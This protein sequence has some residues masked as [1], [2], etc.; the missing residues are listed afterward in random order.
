MRTVRRKW[1]WTLLRACAICYITLAGLFFV[2]DAISNLDEFAR[3]ADGDIY[4]TAQMMGRY[5]LYDLRYY[6]ASLFG[7]VAVMAAIPTIVSSVCKNLRGPDH[8][9]R[10]RHYEPSGHRCRTSDAVNCFGIKPKSHGS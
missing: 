1:Y 2:I 5:Y 3:R 4:R 10:G 8:A 7:V 6:S 9:S